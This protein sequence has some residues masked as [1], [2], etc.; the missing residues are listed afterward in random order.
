MSDQITREEFADHMEAFEQR[1]AARF[2][3]VERRLDAIDARLDSM[4]GKLDGLDTRL[5]VMD[6]RIDMTL[7]A[8][9]DAIAAVAISARN[10]A[11]S[12]RQPRTE[13]GTAADNADRS[14][15]CLQLA[16]ESIAIVSQEGEPLPINGHGVETH[17]VPD[18][19]H[20]DA[21]QAPDS[22]STVSA[23]RPG[24]PE[25]PAPARARKP[26]KPARERPQRRSRT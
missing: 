18:G 11:G 7:A 10:A 25:R 1:F 8:A 17:V 21:L 19:A 23:P 2:G 20:L 22:P 26:A 4:D 5:D 3:R 24:R 6:G 14:H 9:R 13:S 15:G 16:L 12:P